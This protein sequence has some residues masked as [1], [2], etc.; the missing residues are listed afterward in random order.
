METFKFFLYQGGRAYVNAN[1]LSK[2]LKIMNAIFG[3][4]QYEIIQK[5]LTS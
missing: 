3:K 2:A 4:D 5:E 1:S